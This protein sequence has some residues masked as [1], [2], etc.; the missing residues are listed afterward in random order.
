MPCVPGNGELGGGRPD[1]FKAR[2]QFNESGDSRYLFAPADYLAPLPASHSIARRAF[3]RDADR[4]YN[5]APRAGNFRRRHQ[6]G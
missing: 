5:I 2:Q 3:R 4:S 1:D 6:Q